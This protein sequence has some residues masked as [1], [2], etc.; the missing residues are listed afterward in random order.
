M[1]PGG[2]DAVVRVERARRQN[3]EV[4]IE[5]AARAGEDVRRAGEDL[6][7]GEARWVEGTAPMAAGEGR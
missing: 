2:A 6:G 3:G 1:L 4:T 5:A 7:L